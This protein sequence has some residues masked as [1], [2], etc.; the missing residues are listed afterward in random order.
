MHRPCEHALARA[1]L[2]EQ[3][4]GRLALRRLERH[5]QGIMHDGRSSGRSISGPVP[6]SRDSS[7]ATRRSSFLVRS[8]LLK[9]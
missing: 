8:T 9:T 7:S 2:A 1:G 3:Q 5:V 4:D 6:I